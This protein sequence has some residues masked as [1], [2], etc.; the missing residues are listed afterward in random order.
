MTK[1]SRFL[2]MPL[3]RSDS[4]LLPTQ[5]KTPRFAFTSGQ[6][7]TSA[8]IEEVRGLSCGALDLELD[9]EEEVVRELHSQ[10]DL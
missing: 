3:T 7:P 2:L 4:S 9:A 8:E 10:C 6:S 5:A 1:S